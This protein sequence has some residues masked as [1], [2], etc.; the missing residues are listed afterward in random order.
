MAIKI[1]GTTVIDDSRQ[2]LNINNLKVGTGVTVNAGIIT[3]NSIDAAISEW[4]LGADGS[5]HYTFTG[6]GLIGVENDPTIYLKRG[7]KYR[8]KNAS[9]GHPFRIQSTVNGSAG[10]AYDDGITNNDAASGTTLVWNVQFDSPDILYYQ[11][12]SHGAMGGKIYIGNSGDSLSVG[13]GITASAGIITATTFD[14]NATTA[15]TA[16]NATNSSHVLVTDNESENEDNLITFVEDSTSSTGNVGLEMDGNLTYN[17]STGNLSATK[18]T[19][20][21]SGLS[22]VTAS[23]SGVSIKHDDSLVGTA[24]TINF[25]TNLDVSALS[26]GIVTVTASGGGGG[27][28]ISMGKAIA[29]AMVFG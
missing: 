2:I 19:G 13:T 21:G 5:D 11:C 25:S 22:G 29:A 8:F 10:S 1:S 15:T 7:Q 12:T 6:P 3:A 20:D 16:T 26:A 27:G 24:A 23:S 14:G 18:F 28:G 17:P 4:V 9:G